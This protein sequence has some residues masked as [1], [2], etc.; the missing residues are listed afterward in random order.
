MPVGAE[1]AGR[2]FYC[3]VLGMVELQKPPVL[4]A[5]GGCW[6]KSHGAEVHLGVERD[7][8]PATKAHVGLEV[9]DVDQMAARVVAAGHR[10]GWDEELAPRRR[11]FTDDPFGNRLEILGP[12]GGA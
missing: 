9:T 6:F 12:R 1:E 2:G 5:R 7:F 8:R 3:G 11:F 4:H 10:V